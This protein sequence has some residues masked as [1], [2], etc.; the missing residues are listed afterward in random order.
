MHRWN[1][2]FL[3]RLPH[4]HLWGI[5]TWLAQEDWDVCSKPLGSC[6]PS[7]IS[8]SKVCILAAA[9]Q[10]LSVLDCTP[11]KATARLKSPSGIMANAALHYLKKATVFNDGLQ[12]KA[13]QMHSQ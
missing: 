10:P 2:S 4:G 13:D 5:S 11:C 12:V 1:L 8:T 9:L 7:S 6:A 3:W